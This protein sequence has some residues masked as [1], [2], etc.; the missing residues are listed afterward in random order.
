MASITRQTVLRRN[1]AR[2]VAH[3]TQGENMKSTIK[4]IAL[5]SALF[6]FAQLSSA[7]EITFGKLVG[8][9]TSER[10]Q[11]SGDTIAV[12]LEITSDHIFSGIVFENR[13]PVWTY[14]GTCEL[15]GNELTWTYL[16]STRP[17]EP[18]TQDTDV[19]QTIDARKF[20]YTSKLSGEPGSYD[21][22]Q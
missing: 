10:L 21:R 14:A 19:I 2:Y 17:L 13:I 5:V 4:K 22:V 11:P 15:N 6:L 1:Q 18:N 3:S 16:Q 8:K 7:A 9:W 20:T 12:Q